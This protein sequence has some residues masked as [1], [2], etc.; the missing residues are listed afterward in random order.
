MQRA[1]EQLDGSL[2]RLGQG[3]SHLSVSRAR[4][5]LGFEPRFSVGNRRGPA[6]LS[7]NRLHGHKTCDAHHGMREQFG[8]P[9]SKNPG[10]IILGS[11]MVDDSVPMMAAFLVLK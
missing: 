6:G 5:G 8:L 1:A 11:S 9:V 2:E 3:T 7:G 10:N 4:A